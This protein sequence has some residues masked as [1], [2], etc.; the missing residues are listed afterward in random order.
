M[1]SATNGPLGSPR[2]RPVPPTPSPAAQAAFKRCSKCGV[3]YEVERL[4]DGVC[5]S[6]REDELITHE[7]V[8]VRRCAV[9]VRTLDAD[10]PDTLCPVCADNLAD[11]KAGQDERRAAGEAYDAPV[12]ATNAAPPKAVLKVEP[13]VT[14]SHTGLTRTAIAQGIADAVRYS[15]QRDVERARALARAW[16]YR[17]RL[18]IA[19]G[20][21]KD[22][23][24]MWRTNEHQVLELEEKLKMR[25]ARISHLEITVCD[26]NQQIDD[27]R[28]GLDALRAKFDAHGVTHGSLTDRL[29][30]LVQRYENRL[31]RMSSRHQAEQQQRKATIARLTRE[32]D[33]ASRP[34]SV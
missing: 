23:A 14:I 30:Q 1:S 2:S 27:L 6:C 15:Q 28:D 20:N 13:L 29:D 22:S 19:Q 18:R 8:K 17:R 9:C 10:N 33:A 31:D 21:Y 11:R 16:E 5:A 34:A 3:E 12:S 24:A 7:P 26:R 32:L 4:V 25:S